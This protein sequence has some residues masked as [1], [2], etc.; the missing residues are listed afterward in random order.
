MV[1]IIAPDNNFLGWTWFSAVDFQLFLL[2]AGLVYLAFKRP[3]IGI[4]VVC[5]LVGVC[6]IITMI[7]SS[8]YD[9]PP[10]ATAGFFHNELYRKYK[11]T[12][13]YFKIIYN[14][15]YTRFASYGCGVV[16]GIVIFSYPQAQRNLP[17]IAAICLWFTAI[18]LQM[19]CLFCDYGLFSKKFPSKG[20][21]AMFNGMLPFIWS[22]TIFWIIW[23]CCQGYGGPANTF[24][25]IYFWKPL[26][27][28]ERCFLW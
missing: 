16:L 26:G 23:A 18:G 20:G 4:A 28:Q 27:R 14:K 25:S 15:P 10:G 1:I 12:W 3:V 6:I 7:L 9:L 17:R 2:M 24:L 22:M 19:L 8:V 13:Q 21:A 11:N 5:A